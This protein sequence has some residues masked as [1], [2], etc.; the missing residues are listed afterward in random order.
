[1][2]STYSRQKYFSLDFGEGICEAY[3]VGFG[4]LDLIAGL[5]FQD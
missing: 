3:E 5:E 4:Q 2:R 1:M